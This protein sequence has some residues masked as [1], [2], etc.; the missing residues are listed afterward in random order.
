MLNATHRYKNCRSS[1]IYTFKTAQILLDSLQDI[2]Q[3]NYKKIGT[4]EYYEL[5]IRRNLN[6]EYNS[7]DDFIL[8]TIKKNVPKCTTFVMYYK[9]LSY[10][11][12]CQYNFYFGQTILFADNYRHPS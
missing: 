9:N 4:F 7:I 1:N 6:E 11:E 2:I 12:F 8:E 10:A 5:K 3:F